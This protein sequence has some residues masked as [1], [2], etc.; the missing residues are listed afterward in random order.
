VAELTQ[1]SLDSMGLKPGM[2]K[3]YDGQAERQ[4][5]EA[6][7]GRFH[8]DGFHSAESA[9]AV[10]SSS[11]AASVNHLWIVVTAVLL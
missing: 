3:P 8:D 4:G 10:S 11:V 9:T 1:S 5:V 2:I 6:L 7:L